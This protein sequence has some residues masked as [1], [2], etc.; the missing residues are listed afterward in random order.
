MAV[1]I[2]RVDLSEG[3]RDFQSIATEPGLA[4]LD[5]PGANFAILRRW[6]GELVAEPEWNGTLV[7]F[8]VL[9]PEGGRVERV[10]VYPVSKKDITGAL[11]EEFESLEKRMKKAVPES[12]T[13]QL[14]L[15]IVRQTYASLTG[16]LDKSDYDCYF[17][18]YRHEGGPWRLIWC[19]GYQR[20]DLQPCPPL[21]CNN[22]Q[23]NQIFVRRPT[24][25][26]RCPGC[27]K[28]VEKRRPGVAGRLR[29]NLVPLLLLLLLLAGVWAWWNRPRLMVTPGDWH[30]P[31]GSLAPFKV[32]QKSWY[33]WSE[34][35]TD[36]VVPQSSD[37]RVMEFEQ[38]RCI[39]RAKTMGRSIV[40]FFHG[41]Y[42]TTVMV[43]VGP[44]VPPDSIVIEPGKVP[45]LGIGSTAQVRVMGHYK[46]RPAI[47]LTPLAEW[48]PSAEGIVEVHRG[49]LYGTKAGTTKLTASYV[50]RK[51]D[52]P[53]SDAM[54]V[55]VKEVDYV[56]L[57][58]KVDPTELA[59]QQSGGMAIDAFDK[60]GNRY[61][62]LGSQLL[63]AETQSSV[64]ARQQE[65]EQLEVGKVAGD[66]VMGIRSGKDTLRVRIVKP[67]FANHAAEKLGDNQL[68]TSCDF[69]VGDAA[70]ANVFSV[71]PKEI[72]LRVGERYR[73]DVTSP[74][75]EKFEV[76]A[77]DA[78][79]ANIVLDKEGRHP[80]LR[81]LGVGESTVTLKQGKRTAQVVVTVEKADFKAL[82]FE[83][84]LVEL[85]V[86]EAAPLR[87]VGIT[88]DNLEVD[89]A[90]EL[91]EWIKSPEP[92]YV[93]F[94]P[95]DAYLSG[96]KLTPQ[97]MEV[98]VALK[99]NRDM[100]AVGKIAV[101]GSPELA[102]L[103]ALGDDFGAHGPVPV[104]GGPV[105]PVPL[106]V[107]GAY[108]TGQLVD[109]G[110]RLDSI[111]P[112]SPFAGVVPAGA[113]ITDIGGQS[114]AGVPRDE[115]GNYFAP[116]ALA[117]GTPV[118][119]IGADGVRGRGLIPNWMLHAQS[120]VQVQAQTTQVT[121]DTFSAS[122]TVQVREA[123]EYRIADGNGQ[124][125]S[126]FQMI[127]AGQAAQI[128]IANVPRVAGSNQHT[129]FV[130]RNGPAGLERSRYTLE[131]TPDQP[132]PE[133]GGLR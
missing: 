130:E 104:T 31:P 17:F 54:D 19:W 113:T 67:V 123:G 37:T 11:K 44:A 50:A 99:G 91:L 1:Q 63:T 46:D 116:N 12:S 129:I 42:S 58:A 29:T 92:A 51:G 93:F 119:Y 112:G 33:F 53:L 128:P 83:P 94:D 133:A 126:E 88:H 115:L 15:K 21:L 103:A 16:D 59:I 121:A 96:K 34:D 73:L 62:M 65:N 61:S 100:Q 2:F 72:T 24:T 118:N 23:C 110:V 55:I 74:S 107:G 81:G 79:I 48:R 56:R 7:N 102:R 36:Q 97:P 4:M 32:V 47:D 132:T 38:H 10:R 43:E 66:Y 90:P 40:S 28:L 68:E 124:A 52:S 57:E 75:T 77:S 41:R 27:Q 125:L 9:E 117:P 84:A 18:K 108:G 109:D 86:E 8:Y 98:V 71:Q 13:E 70:L 26:N 105:G 22:P 122:I 25:K 78:G 127:G 106:G 120:N 20:T 49:R 131:L 82:R 89:V 64:Q 69:V 39:G 3:A 111:G 80:E 6:F 30:G 76:E 5:R 95:V 87:V 101:V 45:V 35:V 14:L 114:L 85:A 60:E